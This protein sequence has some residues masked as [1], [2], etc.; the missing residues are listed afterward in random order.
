MTPGRW[1]A[2]WRRDVAPGENDPLA[3]SVA[4][5]LR[6]IP[7]DFGG[8]CPP[9][10]AYAMAWLIRAERVRA[11]V[12]IGVYRGRSL[13]PQAVAHRDATGGTAYGVDPYSAIEA[14]QHDNPA[15]RARLEEFLRTTDFEELYRDV[16]RL[17]SELGVEPHCELVRATSARAAEDFAGRGVRFGLIHVDGNHDTAH[18]LEDVKLYLPLLE[19]GGLIVLDDVSWPSVKPAVELVSAQAELLFYESAPTVTELDFAIFRLGGSRR[20]NGAL[21][22]SLRILR[23]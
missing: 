13:M 23:G 12:D 10:K 1:L 11:S 18:V 4:D 16:L 19:R 8:G 22:E 21:R 6:R 17:R 20:R 15:L 14:A 9:K 2:R 5:A 3:A 7:V